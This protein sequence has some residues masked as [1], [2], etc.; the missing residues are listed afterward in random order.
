MV[1]KLDSVEAKSKISASF[2]VFTPKPEKHPFQARYDDG[3]L[4]YEGDW[5]S[6]GHHIIIDNREDSPVQ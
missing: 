5:Y 4:F 2:L 1:T 3:K 6:K